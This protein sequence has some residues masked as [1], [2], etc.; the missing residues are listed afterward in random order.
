MPRNA[1]AVRTLLA[2]AALAAMGLSSG[3]Q[4]VRS[5]PTKATRQYPFWLKQAET[6]PA[7]VLPEGESMIIVNTTTRTFENVDIWLNE[8]YLQH[9]D[10]IGAGENKTLAMADF[11]DIRGEG[12]NPGGLFRY[13]Q[14]TPIRLVQIQ[15]DATSPLLGL[16]TVLTEL[17]TR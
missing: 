2:L 3:C 5:D 11:W 6:L 13:Y 10:R 4:T 1:T 17:E 8:R 16:Q 12:P 9:V 14:P 15:T 7:Q